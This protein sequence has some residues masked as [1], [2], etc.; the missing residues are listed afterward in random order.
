LTRGLVLFAHGARDPQWSAPLR[1]LAQRIEALK[2]DVRVRI[3]FLEIAPPTLTDAVAELSA[4][5][6]QIDVLPVFWASA[7]HVN[8]EL[9]ALVENCRAAHPQIA[10]NVLPTLSELPGLLDLVARQ[11]LALSARDTDAF[12]ASGTSPRR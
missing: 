3:A 12:T 4:A 7:G 10:F 1:D 5:C 6:T 8:N 11:A 9:P 2:P